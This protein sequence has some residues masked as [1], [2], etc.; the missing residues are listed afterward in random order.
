[1]S[2]QRKIGAKFKFCGRIRCLQCT[3]VRLKVG[4]VFD[5][6]ERLPSGILRAYIFYLFFDNGEFSMSRYHYFYSKRNAACP[7]PTCRNFVPQPERSNRLGLTLIEILIAVTLMAIIMLAVV[8]I[9]SR[10]GRE[11]NRTQGSMVIAGRARTAQLQIERDLGNITAP[12]TPPL[13]F[14]DAQGYFCI[15]EGLGSYYGKLA[16]DGIIGWALDDIAINEETSD[17]DSTIGDCDDILMYTARASGDS[18]FRGL[19]GGQVV[20]S[21][22]AEI[23]I[24]LRG[25]TLYRRVLLIIP[26]EKLQE[27]LSDPNYSS[28]VRPVCAGYGFYRDFDVSARLEKD[29]ATNEWRVKAN[30]LADLTHR[31]NRF[32]HAFRNLNTN[33]ANPLPFPYGIHNNAAW[34]QLRLPTLAECTMDDSQSPVSW[35]LGTQIVT[36]TASYDMLVSQMAY[37]GGIDSSW[38]GTFVNSFPKQAGK[39]YI[40]YWNYPLPWNGNSILAQQSGS[41]TST[42]HVYDNAS[43]S[44]FK[45]KQRTNEDVLL[46]NVIG[47]DI[48]VWDATQKEFIDLGQFREDNQFRRTT[49]DIGAAREFS[50]YLGSQGFYGGLHVNGSSVCYA[51][52]GTIQ[53]A[54]LP[55]VYDTWTDAYE[56]DVTGIVLGANGQII[57]GIATDPNYD[58]IADIME[59]VD[60]W[61]C[62]PPYTAPLSGIQIKIR[63]FDANT[64]NIREVTIRKNFK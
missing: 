59:H 48:K 27:V 57:Q 10:A 45:F 18:M 64:N 25:T 21:K 41:L 17:F 58:G 5:G 12:L 55:A 47:F 14:N 50:A 2:I 19:V 33:V 29:D 43:T 28:G 54:L 63:V 42:A 34:Y 9:L 22:E 49:A 31:K 6:F 4:S 23:C 26:D 8:Q 36:N 53:Y 44:T 56:N 60:L 1:M 62:P 35:R 38:D 40:D 61:R 52:D 13:R 20:E 11:L 46:N 37:D 32:G 51:N 3:R 7:L 15:I 30:T 39:P 24:F 16:H